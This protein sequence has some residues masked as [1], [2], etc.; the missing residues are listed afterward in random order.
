[1]I[2]LRICCNGLLLGRSLQP[3][4]RSRR[5]RR[6]AAQVLI[7]GGRSRTAAA[8]GRHR[9]R[10]TGD[11]AR[12]QGRSRDA[13]PDTVRSPMHF[14]VRFESYGGAKIDPDSV[15]VTLSQDPERRPDVPRVKAFIQPTG[16]DMPDVELPA[17]DHMVRVDIKDRTVASGPPAL[18]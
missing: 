5:D 7:T 2:D 1:M 9:D 11:H 6:Y 18:S 14:Q 15:K 4:F 12:T 10:A 16:I 17:G 13:P 3:C 8:E